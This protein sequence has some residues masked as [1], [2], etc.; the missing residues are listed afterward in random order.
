MEVIDATFYGN[1]LGRCNFAVSGESIEPF[2]QLCGRIADGDLKKSIELILR[3]AEEK[4]PPR[5]VN[6]QDIGL[7]S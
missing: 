7:C 3:A 1:V 6:G 2:R 4:Y 5:G